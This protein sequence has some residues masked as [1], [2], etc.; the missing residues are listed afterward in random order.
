V[1]IVVY[2]DD[3]MIIIH[4]ASYAVILSTLQNTLQTIEK[5]C[6]EH[7]LEISKEKSSLMPMFTRNRDEYERHPTRVAWGINVLSKMRYRL[8]ILECKLDWSPHSHHLELKLL[9]IRNRIVRCSKATWGMSF[10]NL[11]TI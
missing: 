8:V 11:L 3:T 4:G 1:R 7:R 6:I 9:R 2:A 10:H 5:W